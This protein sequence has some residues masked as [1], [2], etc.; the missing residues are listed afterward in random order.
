MPPLAWACIG[1]LIYL[2]A[3]VGVL[4]YIAKMT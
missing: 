1:S 3:L 4:I 2:G